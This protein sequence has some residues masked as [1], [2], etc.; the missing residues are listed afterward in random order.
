MV[1]WESCAGA[2]NDKEALTQL[3][4][5]AVRRFPGRS[6]DLWLN[7][8]RQLNNMMQ[9]SQAIAVLKQAIGHFPHD[10][11][12][13]VELIR[14]G[15]R[16]GDMAAVQSANHAVKTLPSPDLNI[17]TARLMSSFQLG[18]VDD[19]L[20]VLDD[21]LAAS[22]DTPQLLATV[23]RLLWNQGR[24][25]EALGA[26]RRFVDQNP[27]NS[28]GVFH[29]GRLLSVKGQGDE[30]AFLLDPERFVMRTAPPVPPELLAELAS[31]I[32]ANPSATRDPEGTTTR[33]GYQTVNLLGQKQGAVSAVLELAVLL[34]D[35]YVA[36]LPSLDPHPFIRSIP[37]AARLAPWTVV[38]PPD[39]RQ[40]P[41]I[42]P[43]GWATGVY[44]VQTPPS[45]IP[46]GGA[47]VLGGISHFP[48][49]K[50]VVQLPTRV[51]R[52]Q[53]GEMV[54]FPSWLQHHTIATGSPIPRICLPFDV[55]CLD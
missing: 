22:I 53:A 47:L 10:G 55:V 52:P 34:L 32:M 38:Y 14:V 7:L 15:I 43:G 54:F 18:D 4:W 24:K 50:H 13:Y 27:G 21:I 30:A 31:E 48:N 26:A 1:S 19:A 11:R 33:D 40:L 2:V 16:L 3:A 29:L 39:G 28:S 5:Q 45:D 17:Q 44:Y 36:S 8:V 12:L 9:S 46:D 35:G 20:L 41:H 6:A 49:R 42:H 37:K 25:A 51:I 23:V